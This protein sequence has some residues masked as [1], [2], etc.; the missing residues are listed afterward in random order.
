MCARG[1]DRPRDS[2]A[3][4]FLGNAVGIVDQT[5]AA[6]E[7]AAHGAPAGLVLTLI[8]A[9]RTLQLGAGSGTSARR[10]VSCTLFHSRDSNRGLGVPRR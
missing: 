8:M 10:P 3:L 9:G 4:M 5:R 6:S 1:M 2:L 7:L